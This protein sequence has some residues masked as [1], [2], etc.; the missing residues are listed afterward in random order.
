M[1]ALLA[2]AGFAIGLALG[3]AIGARR[4]AAFRRELA[5]RKA[6][7]R[8]HVLPLLEHRA[9]GSSVPPAERAHDE[10]DPL[11]AAI[12]LARSIQSTEARADLPYTDTLE[13]GP[14]TP[15]ER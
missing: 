1:G 14:T 4:L 7:L 5:M 11:I 6:E 15:R 9:A 10:R 13:V 12:A 8:S 3:L 2:I